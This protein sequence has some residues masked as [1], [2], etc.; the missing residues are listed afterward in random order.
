MHISSSANMSNLDIISAHIRPATHEVTTEKNAV[1]YTRVS[2]KEQADNYSLGSQMKA[3][4]EYASKHSCHIQGYFG[5]TYES[6]QTDERKEFNRML[7]FIKKSQRQVNTIIVYSLD[8]FSRSGANAIYIAKCLKEQGVVIQSVMQPTDANTASGTLQQNIQFIFSEYDNHL[9]REKTIAGMKEA[10]AK[11]VKIGNAPIG[12]THT[13]IDGQQ[14]LVLNEYAP[15]IKQAFILKIEGY[16]LPKIADRL[17]EMGWKKK[18]YTQHIFK[19]IANPFYCGLL[20]NRMLEKPVRGNH[21]P[22]VSEELWM[23]AN[24]LY[25]QRKGI[26]TVKENDSLPLKKFVCCA[27]CGKPLTGYLVKKKGLYYY[28]CQTHGCCCNVSAKALHSLFEEQLDTYAIPGKFVAPLKLQMR[29]TFQA[30]NA[31]VIEQ[32]QLIL[33]NIKELAGRIEKM[34]ERYILGEIDRPLYEKFR[35]K[36]ADDLNDAQAQLK[37]V[38]LDLSNL[39]N[40]IDFVVGLMSNFKKAWHLADF[41]TRQRFQ[42]LLFPEGIMY[43]K[44]NRAY[45]TEKVNTFVALTA[46]MTNVFQLKEKGQTED[47]DHLSLAG[48]RTGQIS[49]LLGDFKGLLEIAQRLGIA[50]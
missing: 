22:I 43:D 18:L 6:A 16:S 9:R 25:T 46:S 20:V 34:E 47:F 17:K 19:I 49:N 33:A 2:T 1:I 27:D 37:K 4:M 14:Q 45:R 40:Y 7:D 31:K 15:L 11:G 29:L 30:M 48:S 10:L 38:D 50:A 26:I 5:G 12:Y 32:R 41:H 23:Q 3:C 42:N 8:R 39:D 28:K 36:Y 13:R 35:T 21:P 24:G 44:K